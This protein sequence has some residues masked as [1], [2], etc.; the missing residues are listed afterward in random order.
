MIELLS[1]LMLTHGVPEY[2]R[3]DNGSKFTAKQIKKSLKDAESITAY[4]Q[5]GNS[6]ENGY[7]ESFFVRI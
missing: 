3:S 2:L 4:I 1:D 7:I 5:P 6:W